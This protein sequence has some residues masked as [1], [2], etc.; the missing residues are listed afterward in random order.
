LTLTG[1]E[2][3]IE[4]LQRVGRGGIKYLRINHSELFSEEKNHIN[5]FWKMPNDICNASTEFR[6]T[7]ISPPGSAAPSCDVSSNFTQTA[8][9][10]LDLPESRSPKLT[11]TATGSTPMSTPQVN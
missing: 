3:G 6:N 11:G 2:V 4:F 7:S 5:H 8:S 10:I 1:F 9:Y